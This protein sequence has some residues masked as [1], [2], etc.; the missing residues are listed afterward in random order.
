MTELKHPPQEPDAIP[1]RL[2]TLIGAG[3]IV[4]TVVL[5][6]VA[7]AIVQSDLEDQFVPPRP[8]QRTRT[9]EQAHLRT[10]GLLARPIAPP[11]QEQARRSQRWGW[12]DR[13]AGVVHMPLD[14]AMQLRLAQARVEPQEGARSP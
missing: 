10:E 13:E 4:V 11:H 2:L 5:G 6:M 12:V 9:L 1:G 14:V 8:G 7:V 3:V